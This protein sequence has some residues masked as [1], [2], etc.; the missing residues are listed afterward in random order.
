MNGAVIMARKNYITQTGERTAAIYVDKLPD[1]A[2]VNAIKSVDICTARLLTS[3]EKANIQRGGPDVE[4]VDMGG[5]KQLVTRQQLCSQY[6]HCSGRPIKLQYL[7]TDTKYIVY[8]V[9]N[10]TCRVTK[11][12]NNCTGNINGKNIAPGS[13]IIKD[14]SGKISVLSPKLFRKAYKIP[15][16]DVIKRH[17]NGN[18]SRDF[19]IANIYKSESESRRRLQREFSGKVPAPIQI[20]APVQPS[21]SM[22]QPQEHIQN[23][24]RTQNANECARPQLR[25]NASGNKFVNQNNKS[26]SMGAAPT[27][28]QNS[29]QAP[30]ATGAPL[31]IVARLV[32]MNKQLVGFMVLHKASGNKKQMTTSQV[33]ALSKEHKI[34]NIM[35]VTK[36]GTDIQY[37]RGNGIVIQN[38]P[39]LLV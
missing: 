35:L 2:Y 20:N 27:N 4:I 39:E 11:L 38:L 15:L 30:Q 13:F 19:N 25:Q 29:G 34:D 24:F 17:M 32:N 7:R 28:R 12:P 37:L 26:F 5:N 1:C 3:A 21:M 31:T 8:S 9:C 33:K 6:T 36:E 16:N 10:Q 23:S 22:P 14:A 18:V